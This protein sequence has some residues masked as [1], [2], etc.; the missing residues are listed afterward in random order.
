MG[1]SSQVFAYHHLS[2]PQA[3]TGAIPFKRS[4]PAAATLAIMSGKRPTRPTHLALTEQLWA[5]VKRCWD[6]DPHLRPGV[7]EVLKVLGG[8]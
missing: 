1:C 7:S 3:F 4:Q 6:Q 2:L 5:L 8:S